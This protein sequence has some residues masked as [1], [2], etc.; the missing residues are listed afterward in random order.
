MMNETIKK[1]IDHAGLTQRDVATVMNISPSTLSR[2]LNKQLTINEKCDLYA[3]I[4]LAVTK[5][6]ALVR[7]KI[8]EMLAIRS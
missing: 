8:D 3:G 7:K 4:L 1:D 5:K 2:K 6:S